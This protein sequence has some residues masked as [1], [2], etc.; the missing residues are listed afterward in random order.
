MGKLLYMETGDYFCFG[1]KTVRKEERRG[2]G[3]RS[4]RRREERLGTL[5]NKETRRR[6]WSRNWKKRKNQT[7]KA[8]S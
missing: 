3:E 8:H 6:L 5:R 2:R 4:Q 7:P 1:E